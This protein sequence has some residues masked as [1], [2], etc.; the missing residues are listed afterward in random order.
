M[1][2]RKL[3]LGLGCCLVLTL[4]GCPADDGAGDEGAGTEDPGTSTTAVTETGTGEPTGETSGGPTACLGIGGAGAVGDACTSN[5]DCMS[6]VCLAFQDVPADPDAVCGEEPP[7]CAT[8][9]TATLFDFS[10]IVDSGMP[11][12]LG[13]T[14]V[15]VLR[16]L[17]AITDPVMATAVASATPG[18]DGRIDVVTDG[19]ISAPI[20]II[21][22][23]GGGDYFLTATGVASEAD[24][25]QYEVGT[26]IHEFW[27]VRNSTLQAWSTALEDDPD[28][29]E[30]LGM[31]LGT[32][33]GVIGF[34]RDAQGLP[35]EGATVASDSDSSGA[36]IR[37]PQADGTMGTDATA[38]TGTFVILGPTPTGEDFTATAAGMSG[39]GTAGTAN[40]VVFTLILTVS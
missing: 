30:A 15:R 16:A 37:Y 24:G 17:D 13:G 31:G 8:H 38:P 39:G 14:E 6:G 5:G 34:V 18:G 28:A 27:S 26:G 1:F 2:E 35:L 11:A 23:A 22:V 19:P 12:P 25:G 21:A 4:A 10:A 9:V 7:D 36:V 33:G 20:A 3:H 40:N 29:G 32:S